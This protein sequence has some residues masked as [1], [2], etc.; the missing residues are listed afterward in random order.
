MSTATSAMPLYLAESASYE[1]QRILL[2]AC[3]RVCVAGSVRRRKDVCNDVEIVAIPRIDQATKPGEL[4]ASD[5]DRLDELMEIVRRKDHPVLCQPQARPGHNA[6]PWGPR[7]KK[8]YLRHQHRW[9]KVDLW[10]TTR[11]KF[12]AILAIRTGDAEFSKLL[13]TQRVHG[14]AM[15]AKMRQADGSLMHCVHTESGPQWEPLYTPEE[16]EFFGALDLPVLL[17]EQR[18][19]LRL[20]HVL[21]ARQTAAPT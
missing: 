4:L 9:I 8:L 20:R 15:P 10:L 5:V 16:S 11:Q 17:P 13:V 21:Q 18:T 19:A 1:L 2:P 14:G 6:P 3:E 7:Y 12:G